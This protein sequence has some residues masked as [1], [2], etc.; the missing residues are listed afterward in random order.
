MKAAENCAAGRPAQF[1]NKFIFFVNKF[2]QVFSIYA[3][4]VQFSNKKSKK[5]PTFFSH[6]NG[7][8]FLRSHNNHFF[9]TIF[10]QNSHQPLH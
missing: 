2:S 9:G 3:A 7:W 6:E 8:F 10:H 5:N 4:A 1:S